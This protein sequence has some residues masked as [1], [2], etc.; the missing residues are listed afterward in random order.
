MYE[1]VD[2]AKQQYDQGGS[3][4]SKEIGGNMTVS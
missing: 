2:E 1:L 3:V 4:I